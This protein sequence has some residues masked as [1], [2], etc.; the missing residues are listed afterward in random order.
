MIVVDLPE[1][2]DELAARYMAQ[3]VALEVARKV[4]DAAAEYLEAVDFFHRAKSGAEY[5]DK[6]NPA[7]EKLRSAIAE[8]QTILKPRTKEPKQKA[9]FSFGRLA[10]RD[11]DAR[12]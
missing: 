2:Y 1:S 6:F 4:A 12:T 9:P 8:Y 11:K 7:N 10:D 3:A 5:F